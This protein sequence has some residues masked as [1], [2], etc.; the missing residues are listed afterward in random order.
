L[1]KLY[2]SWFNTGDTLY[3]NFDESDPKSMEDFKKMMEKNYDGTEALIMNLIKP[4]EKLGKHAFD[5]RTIT[6][7]DGSV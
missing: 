6:C 5:I 3:E 2:D 7:P 4:D 1:V